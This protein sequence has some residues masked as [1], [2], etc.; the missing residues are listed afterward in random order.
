VDL[1]L[2]LNPSYQAVLIAAQRAR[3]VL[4]GEDE[5]YTPTLRAGLDYTHGTSTSL[6]QS[7]VLRGSNDSVNGSIGVSQKFA[8]GMSIAADLSLSVDQRQVVS[9]LINQSITVG[10]GYGI[11]L[12]VTAVQPL[13]RGLGED[14]GRATQRAA[15]IN[16]TA[17][18]LG[19]RRSASDLA[20]ESLT[21]WT[22]LWY[23]QE[24]LG[25]QEAALELARRSLTVA[26]QRVKAGQSGELELLPIETDIAGQEEALVAARAELR[27]RQIAIA[28]SVGWPSS[29]SSK[30][31]ATAPLPAVPPLPSA[32]ETLERVENNT[33]ELAELSAS[34]ER[35]EIDAGLTRNRAEPRLDATAWLNVGGLGNRAPLDAL[36]MWAGL[37]AV[38]IF[39]G[40][41]FEIPINTT[42]LNS[43]AGASRL[44]V[45]AARLQ[46][47]RQQQVLE[48]SSLE[49]LET[50]RVAEE[51]L[52]LVEHTA[53]LAERSAV[54]QKV[55]FEAGA[56]TVLE[57]L[58]A[59]QESRRA[60][61]RVERVKADRVNAAL[62]V[63]HLSGALLDSGLLASTGL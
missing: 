51:R 55:R 50:W 31:V 22:E 27:R 21:A 42:L 24:A 23:A 3:V 60:Q 15:K 26:T 57:W 17:A 2:G 32:D 39:I 45:K 44:A 20:R 9:P 8:W 28:R 1:A 62:A 19:E 12:R 47:E 61:L 11:N 25:I 49:L 58:S 7:G 5:R 53:E 41:D 29:A 18:Q 6:N 36:S 63:L 34:L 10:P 35:A 52:G 48:A 30:I 14:I 46:R 38:T 4:D 56:G 13:L 59:T 37:E 16:L 40:L 33:P 43:E 54:A